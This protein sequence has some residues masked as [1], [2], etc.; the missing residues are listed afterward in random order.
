[1]EEYWN[2]INHIY[3]ELKDENIKMMQCL[4]QFPKPNLKLRKYFLDKNLITVFVNKN[5]SFVPW[6]V[7]GLLGK[8]PATQTDLESYLITEIESLTLTL[9]VVNH[10]QGSFYDP[11][12]VNENEELHVNFWQLELNVTINRPWT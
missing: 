4:V 3:K 6:G 12:G 10:A 9:N 7:I 11:K 5:S 2:P 8:T 1:M